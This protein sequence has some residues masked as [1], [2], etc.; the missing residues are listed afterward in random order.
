[1]RIGRRRECSICG[2]RVRRFEPHRG[3]SDAKCPHCGALERHRAI[4]LYLQRRTDLFTAPRRV[5]HFAPERGISQ[6]LS[7]LPNLDYTTCDLAPGRAMR[8]IDATE[9]DLPNR[10]VDVVFCAHVLEHVPDDRRAMRELRRILADDGWALIQVPVLGAVTDEDPSVT[11][12]D[13]R[14][15]RFGQEDHVRAYGEDVY[16]RLAAAGFSVDLVDVRD[17]VT[18]DER[19]RYGLD[20]HAQGVDPEHRH[21]WEIP[22]CRPVEP[23]PSRG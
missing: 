12:P 15:A 1:M 23:S 3:R 2:A 11:D 20:A 14:L 18:A 16:T 10:S 4:W 22:I 6:R 5:L 17:V 9:I 19:E 13:E 7:E 21:L 8:V